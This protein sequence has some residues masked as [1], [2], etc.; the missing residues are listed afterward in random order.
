ML[1]SVR[2]PIASVRAPTGISSRVFPGGSEM[3]NHRAG[4]SVGSG[5]HRFRTGRFCLFAKQMGSKKREMLNSGK[6]D[7]GG[8]GRF[9]FHEER[10]VGG[11]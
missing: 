9:R 8:G 6:R 5:A 11:F 2:G 7:V 3:R 4:A 10:D 1:P